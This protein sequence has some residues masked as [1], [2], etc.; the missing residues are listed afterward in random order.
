M[1]RSFYK[2]IS[3][4]VKI[5][6][7]FSFVLLSLFSAATTHA[8]TATQT[9][10]QAIDA[11]NA[12]ITS[13]QQG[14]AT[15]QQA[16]NSDSG[17]TQA[18]KIDQDNIAVYN[19]DIVY[20]QAI[21]KA[22]TIFPQ[23][24]GSKS[25]QATAA[26][27]AVVND[28]A[29]KVA[30][31]KATLLQDQGDTTGAAAQVAAAQT[32]AAAAS[33]SAAT[34]KQAAA[35]ECSLTNL[36]LQGFGNC[37]MGALAV[38][39]GAMLSFVGFLLGFVGSVFNWIVVLT[40]FRFGDYFGNSSGLLL[41]WGILRDIGN[42]ALLA[43][44]IWFGIQIILDINSGAT[45]KAIPALLIAALLL[46]FSLF[47]AEAVI[48]VSDVLSAAMYNQAGQ[49]GASCETSGIN[50]CANTGI[51]AQV[52]TAAGINNIFNSGGSVSGAVSAI[53]KD[54]PTQQLIVYLGL[55]LFVTVTTAVLASAAIIL[56]IRAI[57]L[58][59]VLIA[60]PIGFTAMAIPQAAAFGKKWRDLLLS[61]SFFAPV[62]FLLLLVSLKVVKTITTSLLAGSQ[63]KTLFDALN[64]PSTSTP[65]IIIVFA[66]IT[67]FMIA[68]QM[69][70]KSMGAIGATWATNAANA[71]TKKFALAPARI[72]GGWAYR[73][74]VAPLAQ[75][76]IGGYNAGIG[77]LRA[78]GGPVG[79]VAGLVDHGIGGGVNS[80][81][82]AVRD[83]KVLGGKNYTEKKAADKHRDEI[84]SHAQTNAS[85]INAIKKGLS[86]SDE[87]DKHKMQQALQ[88]MSDGDLA[89]F[90]GKLN[91]TDRE[92]LG[93]NLSTDKLKK[94]LALGDDKFDHGKKHDLTHGRWHT[95][96]K[97]AD[98]KNY[99]GFTDTT[100]DYSVDEWQLIAENDP[101]M[102]TKSL[103]LR[104]P[105]AKAFNAPGIKDNVLTELKKKTSITPQ[106]IRDI[107][108]NR[109]VGQIKALYADKEYAKLTASNKE[110]IK[111]TVRGMSANEYGE[112]SNDEL[113]KPESVP[114]YSKAR[115]QKLMSKDDPLEGEAAT[116]YLRNIKAHRDDIPPVGSAE[117]AAA[118]PDIKAQYAKDIA[119]YDGI[120]RF[121]EKGPGN[122]HYG[123]VIQPP[124]ATRASQRA[125][126]AMQ[127]E[128]IV[129]SFNPAPQQPS[130]T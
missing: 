21:I 9:G 17:N 100:K 128:G 76:G 122:S 92:T 71:T 90:A 36:S 43:A 79:W 99:K 6:F 94:M 2:K 35:A 63:G 37:A 64:S 83:V 114:G 1:K 130:Q 95:A 117:Y 14:T 7:A 55:I 82:G 20:Q 73:H 126:P 88:K 91:A 101:G 27:N 33:S 51:S 89:E 61:Q 4:G 81:L 110:D 48:D 45:R 121:T 3:G 56:L 25:G 19:A 108:A 75:K 107:D 42:I 49:S 120:V 40:V 47:A 60:S 28:A 10:Q 26:D 57:V 34:A 8:Q 65:S 72:G 38:I 58:M 127:D 5:F 86:S 52:L 106:Q 97:Y 54:P 104:N 66:L 53:T 50:A 22:N 77:S 112:L 96:S 39:A 13:D 125:A 12:Q 68:A 111:K 115:L 113:L 84:T 78:R 24:L 103:Q 59:L 87:N 118:S 31:A 23:D 102:M 70:A 119:N 32:D 29:T 80:G 129:N 18:L 85:N 116:T 93:A 69:S 123:N 74:S 44:F 109:R 46:N 15:A 124:R 67:G 16:L 11:A 105:D 62:Y 41:A 30:A 98:E